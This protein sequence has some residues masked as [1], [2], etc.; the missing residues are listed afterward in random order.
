VLVILNSYHDGIPFTLPAVSGGLG[1]RCSVDTN[2]DGSPDGTQFEFNAEYIVTGRSLLLFELVL[3][4]AYGE[5]RGVPSYSH[6]AV[7]IEASD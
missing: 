2:Q 5:A 1:W 4:G 3:D 7:S 6:P